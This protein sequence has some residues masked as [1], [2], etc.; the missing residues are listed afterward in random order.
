MSWDPQH[1]NPYSPQQHA[2]YGPPGDVKRSGGGYFWLW[3]VLGGGG[4]VSLILCCG[5]C[6]WVGNF[7]FQI[8]AEEV[9]SQIKDDPVIEEH[10]GRI[11]SIEVNYAA[12]FAEDD[13]TIWTYDLVGSKGAGRLVV[14][15]IDDAD[16]D[17][18]Q[19]EWATLEL[20]TGDTFDL[21]Q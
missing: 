19:L 8:Q 16:S 13:D 9:R 3:A 21:L 20:D 2:G 6:G 12:S 15:Q 18:V 5:A 10:I 17:A 11:E 4:V 7:A 14:K 1:D